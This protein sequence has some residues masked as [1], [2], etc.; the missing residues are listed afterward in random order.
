MFIAVQIFLGF[1]ILFCQL[2]FTILLTVGFLIH[3]QR[4]LE[5]GF[6]FGDI[7]FDLSV[8]K[9]DCIFV[10]NG[11]FIS[12]GLKS[13]CCC[14]QVS[15]DN[16]TGEFCDCPGCLGDAARNIFPEIP[17]IGRFG[18]GITEIIQEFTRCIDEKR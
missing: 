4:V 1:G 16:V 14:L 9:F 8:I 18:H 2:L 5:C 12:I 15:R 11:V 13:N 3:G 6:G 7:V 17:T 10:F